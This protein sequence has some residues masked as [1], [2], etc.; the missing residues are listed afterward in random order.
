[1]FSTL[2]FIGKWTRWYHVLRDR[3]G[4][5]RFH[6]V[7]YGLW[8]APAKDEDSSCLEWEAPSGRLR[9]RGGASWPN[10][11]RWKEKRL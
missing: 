2:S 6:S 4:F 11:I 8:L 3:N 9:G 7:R 10:K 1:M 5:G